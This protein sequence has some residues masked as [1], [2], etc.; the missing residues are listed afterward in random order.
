[1]QYKFS[2]HE[3]FDHCAKLDLFCMIVF[4]ITGNDHEFN[5]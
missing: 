5:F 3:H 2:L 1:M 4:Q